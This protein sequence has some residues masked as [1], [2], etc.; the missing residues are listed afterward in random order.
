MPKECFVHCRINSGLKR[1]AKKV[2][3]DLGIHP[4]QAVRIFYHQV[5]LTGGI[6]FQL[7]V[8][9]GLTEPVEKPDD[10]DEEFGYYEIPDLTPEEKKMERRAA[11][12][13]REELEKWLRELEKVPKNS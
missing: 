1:K 4:S 8:G 11:S 12:G 2:F 7:S 13:A 5:V 6:P 3:A 9:T 10:S